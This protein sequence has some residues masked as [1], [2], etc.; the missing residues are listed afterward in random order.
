MGGHLRP[1]VQRPKKT[2]LAVDRQREEGELLV[3]RHAPGIT[4]IGIFQDNDVTAYDEFEGREW[5][6]TLYGKGKVKERKD[7]NRMLADLQAE[8]AACACIATVESERMFRSIMDLEKFI[9]LTDGVVGPAVPLYSAHMGHMDLST[10]DGRAMART[11]AAFARREVEKQIERARSEKRQR[12]TRG[13]AYG[14]RYPV[15]GYQRPADKDTH[16]VLE[17]VPDEAEAVRYGAKLV[18]AGKSFRY[19]AGEWNAQ[20]FTTR[21]GQ[22]FS[23]LTVRKI[24]TNA[25]LAGVMEPTRSDPKT[26]DGDWEKVLDYD[27][28][29]AVRQ[30]AADLKRFT[31][32]AAAIA[33][34]ASPSTC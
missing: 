6:R 12:R 11:L 33:A 9:N 31:T 2:H 14:G 18:L 24:L 17:I 10:A 21:S 4:D 34:G 5:A 3:A 27:T 30:V 15:F 8:G 22:P 13:K 29:K 1:Q 26:Q 32:V 25:T 19:V 28:V 20:G 23:G 16:G 7:F